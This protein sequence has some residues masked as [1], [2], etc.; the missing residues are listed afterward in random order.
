MSSRSV[1]WRRLDRTGLEAATIEHGNPNWHLQGTVL[2][3]DEGR[4]CRLDY[5]V[6][7]DREWRTLWAR[8]NGWIGRHQV[9]Q[10][11]ARNL[12]GEWRQNGVACPGVEGCLDVDLAFTPITNLLPIRRLNLA[13]G[14]SAPVRAAWLRFPDFALVP[15]D[16]VYTRVSEHRY[17]YESR[18]GQFTADLE[19][20][21]QG[22]VLRYGSLWQAEKIYT[23]TA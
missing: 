16:Q 18:G 15:L 12:A 1:L 11:V 7:C 3:E 20:D 22:I 8:V 4:P 9:N 5:A 19:V 6:V 10:R 13:S 2:L 23:G 14:S 17:R 21:D